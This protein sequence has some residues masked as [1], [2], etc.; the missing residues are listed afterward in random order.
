MDIQGGN[1]SLLYDVHF[2]SQTDYDVALIKGKKMR[3]KLSILVLL[4]TTGF[5]LS[6]FAADSLRDQVGKYP[7]D[8]HFFQNE[9][10]AKRLADILPASEQ[11]LL[12]TFSVETPLTI[13]KTN[14]DVLQTNVCKP[15]DCGDNN[16]TLYFNLKTTQLAVHFV[17]TG[18]HGAQRKWFTQ[19]KAC[20]V[21]EKPAV[22]A[23]SLEDQATAALKKVEDCVAK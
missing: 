20:N 12:K 16:A 2:F 23:I 10:I 15:H 8:V 11:K 3:K 5:S 4:L 19:K 18:K 9:I 1:S 22:S 7:A 6:T 14:S 13:M 17:E 21:V